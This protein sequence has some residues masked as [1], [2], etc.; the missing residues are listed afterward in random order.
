MMVNRICPCSESIFGIVRDF[1][2][3]GSC[4]LKTLCLFGTFLLCYCNLHLKSVRTRSSSNWIGINIGHR[5]TPPVQHCCLRPLIFLKKSY[6]CN[7]ERD[8]C[9][10][11]PP[12]NTMSYKSVILS[13]SYCSRHKSEKTR[14]LTYVY[15]C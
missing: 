9:P 14:S 15:H 13:Y 5:D 3:D 2:P 6:P 4:Q 8:M 10:L 12:S 11:Q 7:V 1:G